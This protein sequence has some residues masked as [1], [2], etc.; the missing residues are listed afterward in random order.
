MLSIRLTAWGRNIRWPNAQ[1]PFICMSAHTCFCLLVFQPTT[2]QMTLWP[3]SWL[4]SWK[5]DASV[6]ANVHALNHWYLLGVTK[7]VSFDD[8]SYSEQSEVNR[9]L[10]LLFGYLLLDSVWN[11]N[12]KIVCK[13]ILHNQLH[14][15]SLKQYWGYS[16][17]GRSSVLLFGNVRYFRQNVKYGIFVNTNLV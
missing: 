14:F 9:T 6:F 7:S 4:T 16:V 5:F 2:G 13:K 1:E 3:V 15:Y 8:G 12:S 11:P 17:R 10:K